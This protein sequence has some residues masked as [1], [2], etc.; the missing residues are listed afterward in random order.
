MAHSPG[1]GLALPRGLLILLGLA[2]GVVSIAGIR[3]ASGL[4]GPIFL[5]LVLTVVQDG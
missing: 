5:A 4:I 1:P 2:A 3:S